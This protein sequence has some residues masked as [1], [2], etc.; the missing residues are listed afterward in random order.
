M[1]IIPSGEFKEWYAKESTRV[2]GTCAYGHCGKPIT[3]LSGH[4]QV[5]GVFYHKDCHY[6]KEL[7]E[8][9]AHID[10]NPIISPF[11][12]KRNLAMVVNS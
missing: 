5:E 10:N 1:P 12:T 3:A 7:D 9:S 6:Q 8:F 11:S 4:L 2:V